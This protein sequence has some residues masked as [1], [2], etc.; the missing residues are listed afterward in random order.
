MLFG[1]YQFDMKGGFAYCCISG[2]GTVIAKTFVAYR[3]VRWSFWELVSGALYSW[4][5]RF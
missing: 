1:S 4:T 3:K 2:D 5:G